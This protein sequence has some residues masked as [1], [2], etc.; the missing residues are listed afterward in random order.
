MGDAYRLGLGVMQDPQ[1]SV[2]WYIKSAEQGF[3]P[4]QFYMGMAYANG[5]GVNQSLAKA[6]K[7]FYRASTTDTEG[8]GTKANQAY[9]SGVLT[10]QVCVC[11][12]GGGWF[13]GGG[14]GC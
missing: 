8:S 6:A 5:Q 9:E 11:V 4:A 12:C 1:L 14:V 10:R 2:Q 7:W 3:C 13:F